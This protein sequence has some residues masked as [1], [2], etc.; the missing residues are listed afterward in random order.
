MDQTKWKSVLVPIEVY[1]EIRERSKREGRTISSE[2]RLIYAESE[3]LR[4][5]YPDVASDVVSE[6]FSNG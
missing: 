5:S 2:L 6:A 3:R 4:G 1:R